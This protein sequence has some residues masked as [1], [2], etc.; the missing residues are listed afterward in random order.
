MMKVG[1]ISM[2]EDKAN[3]NNSHEVVMK[4]TTHDRTVSESGRKKLHA[5]KNLNI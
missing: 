5:V 3:N 1:Q 2:F 4:T